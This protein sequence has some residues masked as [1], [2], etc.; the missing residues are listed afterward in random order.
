MSHVAV[1]TGAPNSF[2]ASSPASRCSALRL[3]TA[4]DAPR[5]ANSE[6]MAL[7]RP[8]PAP[9]TNTHAPSNVPGFRAVSPGGGGCGRPERSDTST[10][11]VDGRTLVGLGGAHLG[12]VVAL[13]DERLV[14]ELVA[15]RR[16]L[17]GPRQVPDHPSRHLDRDRGRRGDLVGHLTGDRV[18]L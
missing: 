7:P 3:A 11:S 1:T 14:D 17:L 12:E 13:V 2:I 15:H 16:L 18:E 6:A 4:I 5:R 10:P 9:V 8:V